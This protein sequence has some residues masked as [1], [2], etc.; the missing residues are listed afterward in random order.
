MDER[1]DGGEALVLLQEQGQGVWIGGPRVPDQAEAAGVLKL[2]NSPEGDREK[3]EVE[4]LKHRDGNL[5]PLELSLRTAP[6]P[7]NS[8]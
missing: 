6:L 5:V 1:I 4:D 3:K 8:V 7:L 2:E